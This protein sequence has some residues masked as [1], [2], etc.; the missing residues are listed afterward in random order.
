MS[1]DLV[2]VL[3][4]VLAS[5]VLVLVLVLVVL[6]LV[7]VLACPVLVNLTGRKFIPLTTMPPN[8]GTKG[9]GSVFA[10]FCADVLRAFCPCPRYASSTECLSS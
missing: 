5:L 4:L 10:K 3:V 9:A 6:V 8:H 2:L 1:Q 7:L